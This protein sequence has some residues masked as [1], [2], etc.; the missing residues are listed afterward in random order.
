K[1]YRSG[2]FDMFQLVVRSGCCLTRAADTSQGFLPEP[3]DKV[4]HIE[5]R[6]STDSLSLTCSIDSN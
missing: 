3:H 4:K 5:L 2:R 6:C 1:L